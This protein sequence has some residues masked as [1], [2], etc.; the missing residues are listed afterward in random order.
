MKQELEELLKEWE[1]DRISYLAIIDTSKD[2]EVIE[3]YK[4]KYGTV[5][6]HISHLKSILAKCP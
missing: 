5:L 2:K 6:N 1:A 3:R 4:G